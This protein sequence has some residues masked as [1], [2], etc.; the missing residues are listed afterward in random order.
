MKHKI[1]INVLLIAIMLIAA[2]T[3][4]ENA[5]AIAKALGASVRFVDTSA[6]GMS[7][8]IIFPISSINA[9]RREAKRQ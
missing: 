9:I 6:A 8:A 1:I 3:M 7:M 4:F 2:V 5:P